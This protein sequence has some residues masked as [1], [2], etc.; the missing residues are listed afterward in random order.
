MPMPDYAKMYRKLFNAQ[1][2]AISL[3]QKAQQD[4]ETLYIEADD[5][6]IELL[7][8]EDSPKDDE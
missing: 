4:A 7:P 6:S 8:K 3:L 1:T 5:T 2:D